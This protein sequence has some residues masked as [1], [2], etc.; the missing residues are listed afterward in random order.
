MCSSTMRLPSWNGPPVIRN[1]R[2]AVHIRLV[3]ASKLSKHKKHQYWFKKSLKVQKL[4]YSVS[5]F[6]TQVLGWPWT[7]A[8]RPNM[9]LNFFILKN[10][11]FKVYKKL[12]FYADFKCSNLHLWKNTSKY[13]FR[14]KISYLTHSKIK[15]MFSRVFSQ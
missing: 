15:S 10:R 6:K 9:M 1:I 14:R 3:K 11:S 7:T 13:G 4:K 12:L 5:I 8:C 2:N